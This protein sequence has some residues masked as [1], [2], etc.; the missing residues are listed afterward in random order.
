MEKADVIVV[1]SGVIGTSTAYRLVTRGLDVL[2]LDRNGVAAGTSGACDQ[3][4][5]L[6]SKKPGRHLELARASAQLYKSLEEELQTDL[7]YACHGGMVIIET[8][9]QLEVMTGFVQQQ[10]QAGLSVRLISGDEARER[11][12][13]LASHIVGATWGEEDAQVNPALLAFGFARAARRAGVRLRFGVEVTGL[14]TEGNR[15]GGVTTSAG[16]MYSQW[17]VLAAG[18]HTPQL[19]ATVGRKL[20][21]RPRRG[22]IIITE[23]VRPLIVGDL[24]CARYIASKLDPTLGADSNDP[25]YRL[26][27]GL[28][29]GQTASGNLLIGGSREFVG[30]DRSTSTEALCAIVQHA[31]R[32]MPLLAGVRVIRAM[33]G[34]RPHTPDSLPIIGPDRERTGLMIAAG[35]EGDGI[36]LSPITGMMVAD[37]ITGGPTAALAAGL[38]PER[39]DSY[40]TITR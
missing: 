1:G 29:L 10:Q 19:A 20:P 6:Q 9:E 32:I 17:V 21:I 35:H 26:G 2:L 31:V 22:Q 16:P 33:A 37:L 36:A 3:A 4:I 7:E 24:N 14:L 28:S 25:S 13:G 12:P 11:Q 27:V 5:L 23:P 8:K 39:F 15:V 34:L 30:F 38:G 40:E 18:P